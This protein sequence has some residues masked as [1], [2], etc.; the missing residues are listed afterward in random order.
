MSSDEVYI[1][2]VFDFAVDERA[3][4]VFDNIF[5]SAT[6]KHLGVLWHKY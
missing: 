3:V 4:E 2:S 1:S 6:K 5:R